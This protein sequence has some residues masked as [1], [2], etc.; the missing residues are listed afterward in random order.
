LQSQGGGQKN[1]V[2]TPELLAPILGLAVVDCVNPSAIAV[3]AILMS[4]PGFGLR[5]PI[6][7]ASV[8][9]TYLAAGAATLLGFTALWQAIEPL[10]GYMGIAVFGIAMLAYALVAPAKPQMPMAGEDHATSRAGLI[11]V[12]AL[13]VAVTIAE[14]P[15]AVPYAAAL[16]LL[17]SAELAISKWLPVLLCYNAI[18]VTPPLAMYVA[19]LVFRSRIAGRVQRLSAALASGSRTAALWLMGIA[20]FYITAWAGSMAAYEAG[21]LDLPLR[22]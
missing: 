8:F 20:G 18:F 12:A 15:T 4:R 10:Y 9:T 3:T 19:W 22:R 11:G 1:A 17:G 5:A 16:A 2:M 21:L 7:I 14:L 6:Y 13:G